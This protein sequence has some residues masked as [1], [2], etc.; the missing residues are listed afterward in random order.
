MKIVAWDEMHSSFNHIL[1][2]YFADCFSLCHR[3]QKE[4][5]IGKEFLDYYIWSPIDESKK[6]LNLDNKW[7]KVFGKLYIRT[8]KCRYFNDQLIQSE[9]NPKKV[10]GVIHESL[11]RSLR[12]ARSCNKAVKCRSCDSSDTAYRFASWKCVQLIQ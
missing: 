7:P 12:G 3:S 9:G 4:M 1:V 8:A 5:A 6:L 10:R 11:R 2:Y